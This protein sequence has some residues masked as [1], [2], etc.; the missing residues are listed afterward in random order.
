MQIPEYWQQQH[1]WHSGVCA[2]STPSARRHPVLWTP[3]FPRMDPGKPESQ[4]L[5][6]STEKEIQ[7]GNRKLHRLAEPFEIDPMP[8]L[9][10]Q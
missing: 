9:E 3:P 6:C 2:A 1:S 8:A 4:S 10:L 7:R 5:G